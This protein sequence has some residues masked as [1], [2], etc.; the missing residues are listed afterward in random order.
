[1]KNDSNKL[2]TEY[3][4]SEFLSFYGRRLRS[5]FAVVLGNFILIG[6]AY[7]FINSFWLGVILAIFVVVVAG[8]LLNQHL[9]RDSWRLFEIWRGTIFL[10][11]INYIYGPVERIVFEQI[12][13]DWRLEYFE[14][15]RT[16]VVKVRRIWKAFRLLVRYC[17]YFYRTTLEY[18][19]ST[20]VGEKDA[21]YE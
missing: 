7:L 10:S 11:L 9:I 2:P 6:F 4:L 19:S 3:P 16:E 14:E 1:M 15:N 20:G 18:R 8:S 13:A 5:F 12:I 21:R 17:G